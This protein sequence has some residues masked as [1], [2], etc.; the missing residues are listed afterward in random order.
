MLSLTTEELIEA[1]RSGDEDAW[2]GIY[3]AV[4]PK[5]RG[6]AFARGAPDPDAIVGTTFL[7]AVEK[8]HDFTGDLDALTGWM[9]QIARRKIIDARRRAAFRLERP[10]SEP[11][12]GGAAASAEDELFDH[13]TDPALLYAI[14]TLPASQQEVVL[15]R[16]VHDFTTR[17]TAEI[18]G[19]SESNVKVLLHRALSRLRR[20]L[21]V[22]QN[23]L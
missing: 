4:A 8:I 1:A 22:P 11:K 13:T 14:Q 6:F 19:K 18:L 15:L 9:F 20:N 23:D 21:G 5:L 17:Q 2:R 3:E 16:H 10:L 7:V 12:H